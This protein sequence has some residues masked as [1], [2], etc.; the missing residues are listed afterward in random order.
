MD[1]SLL[2]SES[3]RLGLSGSRFLGPH[4]RIFV[5]LD[6]RQRASRTANE[7][8]VL[9]QRPRGK[10]A[11]WVLWLDTGML[12][13]VPL[14]G[15]GVVLLPSSPDGEAF[16]RYGAR[17]LARVAMDGSHHERVCETWWSA[18]DGLSPAGGHLL[19]RT[20]RGLCLVRAAGSRVIPIREFPL[21]S[22]RVESRWQTN[23]TR[24]VVRGAEWFW[25]GD[26]ADEEP[27]LTRLPIPANAGDLA[28]FDGER[29]LTEGRRV[30]LWTLDGTS[31]Q[32][33]PVKEIP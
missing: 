32:L 5:R 28:W 24:F 17:G 26:A 33:L 14:V 22:G 16:V 23:G 20:N 29:F 15:Q 7:H 31:R 10:F 2:T 3:L 12:S 6:A 9:I 27:S 4:T 30:V 21:P 25:V 13:P 8:G 1:D 18:S 19:G 11:S